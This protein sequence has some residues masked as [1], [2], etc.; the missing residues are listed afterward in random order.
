[1]LW[2]RAHLFALPQV[3]AEIENL[4][5]MASAFPHMKET[6]RRSHVHGLQARLAGA[7]T[8]KRGG[9]AYDHRGY[10]L[11]NGARDVRRWFRQIGW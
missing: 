9:D 6:H 8:Y 5:I 3:K 1:M 11:L 7:W 2:L 10:R 4:S